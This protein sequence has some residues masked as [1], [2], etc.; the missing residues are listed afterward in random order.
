MKQ[1]EVAMLAPTNVQWTTIQGF[2]KKGTGGDQCTRCCKEE[3]VSSLRGGE[4][5]YCHLTKVTENRDRQR[6]QSQSSI[7]RV[8]WGH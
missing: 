8:I 7:S 5:E 2:T 4:F 6:H 1:K 3:D